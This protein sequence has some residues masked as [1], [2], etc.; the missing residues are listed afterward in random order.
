MITKFA[1]KRPEASQ[2]VFEFAA[3]MQSQG[4]DI[5]GATEHDIT[6]YSESLSTRFEP[7]LVAER[8]LVVRDLYL[9]IQRKA[10]FAQ[11]LRYVGIIILQ[12][13]AI[14]LSSVWIV[15]KYDWPSFLWLDRLSMFLFGSKQIFFWPGFIGSITSF[16][17]VIVLVARGWLEK[18]RNPLAWIVLVLNWWILAV[19]YGLVV[20]DERSFFSGTI[21]SYLIVGA[22]TALVFGFKQI[23]GVA[24]LALIVLAGFNITSVSVKLGPFVFPYLA[25]L[26]MAIF[27][28]NPGIFDTLLGWV[29]AQFLSGKAQEVGG[30]AAKSIQDAASLIGQAASNL[31]GGLVAAKKSRLLD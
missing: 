26:A 29:N 11:Y 9:E 22:A 19:L 25:T 10:R 14:Y 24:L 13:V 23:V 7:T 18:P 3:F 12:A 16:V 6:A 15:P 4:K 20:G 5:L 8:L 30:E 31:A 2:A 21:N 1:A 17:I 27:A 28:Q